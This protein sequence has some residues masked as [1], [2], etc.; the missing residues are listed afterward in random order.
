MG[1]SPAVAL[2]LMAVLAAVLAGCAEDESEGG[3]A[4]TGLTGEWVRV[5]F[6]DCE[7]DIPL[8]ELPVE[9]HFIY[10]TALRVEQDDGSLHFYASDRYVWGASR[11]ADDL[12]PEYGTA[13]SIDADP[14][15]RF[16]E[17]SFTRV[18]HVVDGGGRLEFED[19]YE[20]HGYRL[21]C[22]HYFER[23]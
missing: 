1:R 2:L 6:P 4:S 7:G 20:S 3:V 11:S 5:G 17:V 13:W 12:I 22:R 19:L 23:P 18:G 9:Q 15:L 10:A 14:P 8:Q 16:A 21:T